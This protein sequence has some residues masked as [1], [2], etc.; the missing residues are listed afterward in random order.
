VK[1]KDDDLPDTLERNLGP[2]ADAAVINAH[3][4]SSKLLLLTQLGGGAFGNQ[5]QW[6]LD[7]MRRA[8]KKLE[9]VGLD[10]RVV[11]YRAPDRGLERLAQE[12]V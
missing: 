2:E 6:I 7:A 8:L 11:S 10:V 1:T 5:P 9:G 4:F 12:F 3:R